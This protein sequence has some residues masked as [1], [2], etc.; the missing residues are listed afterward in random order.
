MPRRHRR[1]HEPAS[2]GVPGERVLPVEPLAVDAVDGDAYT[3]FVER[4]NEVGARL[5]E[6]GATH[7]AVVEVCRQLDGLPLA[8][9]LAAARIRTMSV[10]EMARRLDERFR[11]LA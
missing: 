10:Q 4:A 3:L 6:D 5:D 9:E 7:A 8:I 2:L 1:R 11:L